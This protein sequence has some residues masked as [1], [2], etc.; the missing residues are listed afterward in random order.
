MTILYF[1]KTS[2]PKDPYP[3]P[4]LVPDRKTYLFV[5]HPILNRHLEVRADIARRH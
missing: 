2:T 3:H 4:A 1:S 5:E